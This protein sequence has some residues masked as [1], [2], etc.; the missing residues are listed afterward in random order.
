MIALQNIKIS[1]YRR[2]GATVENSVF[3]LPKLRYSSAR[4]YKTSLTMDN[5]KYLSLKFVKGQPQWQYDFITM[6]LFRNYA[7]IYFPSNYLTIIL[8][9]PFNIDGCR[10][11]WTNFIFIYINVKWMECKTIPRRMTHFTIYSLNKHCN[12]VSF[13]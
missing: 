12:I 11:N 1:S 8:D 9:F 6:K 7:W 10:V 4:C 13:S 3:S 2:W 5:V